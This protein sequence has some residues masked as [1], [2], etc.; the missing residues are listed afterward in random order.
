MPCVYPIGRTMLIK[1]VQ[2]AWD[3]DLPIFARG[4][5][6]E[7]VGDEYGWLG[8]FSA[9]GELICVLPF[10][11]VRKPFFRMARF[12][13]E[14]IPVKGGYD[15]AGERQFLNGVIEYFR[16]IH[17]DLVVPATTNT[18]FRAYPDKAAVAPYGSYI[19]DLSPPEETLWK[20]ID[21]IMRQNIKTAA[22][23]GIIVRE[24]DSQVE[25]SY[26]LIKDTFHRSRL[27]FMSLA[28]FKRFLS[29]LGDHGKIL[30]AD[31]K[32][33][34]QSYVVFAYSRYGVFAIYAGNAV[35][36]YPGSNK[37]L[38][39]EA[40]RSFK[41]L[42]VR[43]Y[44]FVGSRINPEKGSKQEA[45]AQFKQRFGATLK[46]GYMWKCPLHPI[47]YRLYGLIARLRSGGD[48]V[49]AERHKM[50]GF[51]LCDDGDN[52]SVVR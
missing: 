16:S 51:R 6:L 25:A 48:I 27:P 52:S 41:Q 3:E 22:K 10:T 36:Q 31:Y 40:I 29:G 5:F 47:K 11:I 15:R 35:D 7:K 21:R 13:V 4:S 26:E 49:D 50:N 14:T 19:I 38:Y 20:N 37:L 1:P 39:W 8:G 45:L 30:A 17:V 43:Q 24:A 12:R 23:H 33:V 42:G 34:P 44:D 46:Q 2:L 9:S 32:G 18:I 28:S